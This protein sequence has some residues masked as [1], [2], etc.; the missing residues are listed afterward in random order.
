ML[1]RKHEEE[2]QIADSFC[3]VCKF[4]T[5]MVHYQG[6]LKRTLSKKIQNNI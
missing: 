1:P 5:T 4:L 3:S 2:V 6:N